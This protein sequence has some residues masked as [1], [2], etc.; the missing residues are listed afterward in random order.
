[1][2]IM[3]VQQSWFGG[4]R[5]DYIGLRIDNGG[6]PSIC[7]RQVEFRPAQRDKIETSA[8]T[9]LASAEVIWPVFT[10]TSSRLS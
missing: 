9:R 2:E 5:N 7:I 3:P 8:R 10:V 6:E 4:T 1:M